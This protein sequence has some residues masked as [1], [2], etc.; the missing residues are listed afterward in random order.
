MRYERKWQRKGNWKI[1]QTIMT[2]YT[3]DYINHVYLNS[4]EMN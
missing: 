2:L 3:A 4:I 1:Q